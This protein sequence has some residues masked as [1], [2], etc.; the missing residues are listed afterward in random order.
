MG[1]CASKEKTISGIVENLADLSDS[2]E[3]VVHI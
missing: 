2:D 1:V 3:E